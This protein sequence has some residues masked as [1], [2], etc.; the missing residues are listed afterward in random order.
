[1]LKFL[2]EYINIVCIRHKDLLN[3]KARLGLLAA[4]ALGDN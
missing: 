3:Q 2:Q 1:M 4:A